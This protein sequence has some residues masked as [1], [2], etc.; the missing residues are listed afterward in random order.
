MM[1]HIVHEYVEIP[2]N[3]LILTALLRGHDQSFLVPYARIMVYQKSFSPDSI[4]LWNNLP[5]S[6]IDC[7]ALVSFKHKVQSI[8]YR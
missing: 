3:L 4:R 8:Q 2:I 7:A 5:Q 6:A 1:Y